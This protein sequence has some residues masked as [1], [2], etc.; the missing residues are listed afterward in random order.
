MKIIAEYKRLYLTWET[1]TSLEVGWIMKLILM[2]KLK[3]DSCGWCNLIGLTISIVALATVVYASAQ[4]SANNNEEYL[5]VENKKYS[6][7]V[8][9]R[10]NCVLF[11]SFIGIA[12]FSLY[13]TYFNFSIFRQLSFSFRAFCESLLF[14]SLLRD[15][16]F[17]LLTFLLIIITRFF[18]LF[19]SFSLFLSLSP[20]WR[21]LSLFCFIISLFLL[22]A[23]F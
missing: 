14:I 3:A 2:G 9:Y 23:D 21:Q 5:I 10:W 15:G 11:S 22:L 20:H 4:P 12:F 16:I 17:F 8:F 6:V 7:K 13:S 19:C 1:K 18:V